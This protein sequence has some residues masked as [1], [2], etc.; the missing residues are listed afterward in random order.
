M[1]RLRAELSSASA[2]VGDTFDATI[3]EPVVND[4]QTLV[5]HGAAAV[6]RVLAARR[7]DGKDN[8]YLRISLVSIQTT[9]KTVLLDTSSIFAK[10][11][12]RDGAPRDVVFTPDRRLTFH[13]TKAVD[14]P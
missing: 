11:G 8:G 7:S 4:G 1:I 5:P 9:G 3:D 6:G 2:R 10:G 13:L 14:L 12:A